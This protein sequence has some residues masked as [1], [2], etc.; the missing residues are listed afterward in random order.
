ML[1]VWLTRMLFSIIYSIRLSFSVAI[2]ISSSSQCPTAGG[3]EFFVQKF[4]RELRQVLNFEMNIAMYCVF[5]MVDIL[6]CYNFTGGFELGD[7]FTYTN[8]SN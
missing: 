8:C 1:L 4:T 6:E 3:L 5:K 2:Q 7:S